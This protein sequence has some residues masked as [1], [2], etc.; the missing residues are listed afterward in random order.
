M[1][2]LCEQNNIGLIHGEDIEKIFAVPKE[3]FQ[4][5]EYQDFWVNQIQN[6]RGRR[7]KQLLWIASDFLL[8]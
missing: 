8:S 7:I 3:M 1:A 2:P 5:S 4:S 6:T